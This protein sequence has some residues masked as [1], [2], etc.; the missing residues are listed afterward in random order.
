MDLEKDKEKALLAAIPTVITPDTTPGTGHHAENP[1]DLTEGKA[2][3]VI[4]TPPASSKISERLPDPEKF[5]GN[6]KDLRRFTQQIYSKLTTNLDRFTSANSRLA[7]V[8]SRLS[9]PAYELILPKVKYGVYQFVDYPQMLTY[10][11]TAFGDPDRVKNAQNDLF[12]LR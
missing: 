3:A 6:R 7:Y 12:R 5:D 10:L 11:E 4:T 9:G 8:A 1:V 2:T